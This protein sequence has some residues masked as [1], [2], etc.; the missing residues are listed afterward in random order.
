VPGTSHDVVIDD[1][2]SPEAADR[3]RADL[4][5]LEF[6]PEQPCGAAAMAWRLKLAFTSIFAG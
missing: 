3:R 1:V 2:R 5:Q 4:V 6:A